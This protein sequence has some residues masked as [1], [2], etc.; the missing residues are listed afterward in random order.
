MEGKSFMTDTFHEN[1]MLLL[2][3]KRLQQRLK[4]MNEAINVLTERNTQLRLEKEMNNWPSL[5][6]TD[7]SVKNLIQGYIS[8]IEKLQAKLIESEEMY[9][10]L[11]KNDKGLEAMRNAKLHCTYQGN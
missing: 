7:Q 10:Q 8:E 6:E 1:E 9:Q 3:N 11:R 4:S 2:D 5:V